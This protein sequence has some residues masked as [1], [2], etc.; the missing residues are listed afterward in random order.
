M[1]WLVWRQVPTLFTLTGAALIVVSG[2]YIALHAS[3]DERGW[4]HPA[5]VP[6]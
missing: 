4:T 2:I 1:A 3:P 5:T 6:D